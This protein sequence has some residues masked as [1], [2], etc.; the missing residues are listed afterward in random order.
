MNRY[1][2]RYAPE[3]AKKPLLSEAIINTGVLVNI[4]SSEADYSRDSM[5]VAVVGDK[6]QDAKL[7]GYLRA[8]GV[9]VEKLEGNIVKDDLKCVDCCACYGVCP[10]KAITIA[11]KRMV[12]DNDECIRCKACVEACPTRAL[13]MQ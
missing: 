13:K 4:L 6:R 1:V 10:T 3:D 11:D 2:L 9:E 5:V 8:K 7:I 12:L